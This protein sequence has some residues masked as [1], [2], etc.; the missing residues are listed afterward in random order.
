MSCATDTE[1]S[2]VWMGV[3]TRPPASKLGQ[4]YLTY[5]VER[6]S[7]PG[8]SSGLRLAPLGR[9]TRNLLLWAHSVQ[10]CLPFMGPNLAPRMM[11][12]HLL[13]RPRSSRLR[14]QAGPSDLQG[15]RKGHPGVCR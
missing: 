14:A 2:F 15:R 7:N 12:S 1:F 10:P 8:A 9:V 3:E 5:L 11:T 13:A 6:T 4:A